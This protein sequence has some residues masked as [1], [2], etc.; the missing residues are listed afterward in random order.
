MNPAVTSTI[1]QSGAETDYQLLKDNPPESRWL[2]GEPRAVGH[3]LDMNQQRSRPPKKKA[4]ERRRLTVA[5]PLE[6]L[7][8]SRNAV[9][10][11][12][13]LTLAR[14]LEQALT[15]SLDQPFPL[16]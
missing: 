6:L 8:R 3:A 13:G 16:I 11:T 14:L 10:W 7:E 2:A 5:L 12:K 4:S 15:Q 1:E 9:Y